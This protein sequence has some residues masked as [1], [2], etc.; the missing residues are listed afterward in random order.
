MNIMDSLEY[1]LHIWTF[2]KVHFNKV[3]KRF[4]KMLDSP[5]LSYLAG[6]A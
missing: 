3:F 1:I 5:R 2:L 6:T 4:A